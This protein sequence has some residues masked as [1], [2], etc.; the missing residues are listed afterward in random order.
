M[1]NI[2]KLNTDKNEK[3]FKVVTEE[4]DGIEI[5]VDVLVFDSVQKAKEFENGLVGDYRLREFFDKQAIIDA[6]LDRVGYLEYELYE[7]EVAK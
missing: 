2:I 1:T 7:R 3:Y 6:L 5:M 4:S